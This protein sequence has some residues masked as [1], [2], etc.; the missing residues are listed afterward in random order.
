[1]FTIS[2]PPGWPGPGAGA[3]YHSRPGPAGPRGQIL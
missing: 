3:R 2:Q 1:M